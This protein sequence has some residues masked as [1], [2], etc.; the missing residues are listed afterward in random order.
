MI[1]SRTP[2]RI[3][4]F[5]GGT[6][7]PRWYRQHGGAVLSTT[8]NKY[9][10]LSVRHLPPFFSHKYRIVYSQVEL[11]RQI[12]E[13]KHPAIRGIL[14]DFG[15]EQGLEIHHDADLPARSG[16]GSSSAFVVGLIHALNALRGRM[17]AKSELAQAAVRME[18]EVLRENVG[19]QDQVSAAWGGFNRF[20]FRPNG[21]IDVNPITLPRERSEELERSLLLCFT[22][23]TRYATDVAQQTIDNLQYRAA[24]LTVLRAMVDE[25]LAILLDPREPIRRIGQL[26]HESWLL[27]RSLAA[28]VTTPEIDALYQAAREAGASGGKLMGAGGGGFM[29]FVVD[30]DQRAR[31]RDR[32]RQLV[33]V[34][35]RFDQSGSRIVVYDPDNGEG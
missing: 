31:L 30:P 32:L 12:A 14:A 28:V 3:S 16:L 22:G 21:S 24:E 7:Y 33:L 15:I 18:Q 20:D 26:M 2:F 13:I 9:C 5:G 19:C 10:Y 27:K 11:A 25:A 29:V 34:D 1:I 4:L 23:F 17:I 8:I 6:D 35:V